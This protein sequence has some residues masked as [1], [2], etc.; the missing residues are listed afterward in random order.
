MSVI[1][2]LLIA[3]LSVSVLFLIAFLWNVKHQQFDDVESPSMRMLF[4]DQPTDNTSNTSS[5]LN[6]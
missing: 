1:I 2:L 3:S 6:Q 4:E 5:T